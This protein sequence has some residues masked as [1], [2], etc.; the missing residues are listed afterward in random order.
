MGSRLFDRSLA[1]CGQDITLQDR[2][3]VAPKHGSVDFDE[4]FDDKDTVKASVKTV[5][6]K[7]FFDGVNTERNIT[8]EVRIKYLEGVTA[9]TW[10]LFKGRRLDILNVV[11]CCETDDVLVLECNERGSANKPAA[12]L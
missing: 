3:I 9:Q 11:N 12:R 7:T 10:L 4:N 1:K 8:H 2:N 5:R 6:G